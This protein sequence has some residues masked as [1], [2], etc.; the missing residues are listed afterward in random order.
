MPLFSFSSYTGL[1]MTLSIVFCFFRALPVLVDSDE[2][3]Y[4]FLLFSFKL[5]FSQNRNVV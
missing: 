3:K 2:V 5:L 1:F 4:I